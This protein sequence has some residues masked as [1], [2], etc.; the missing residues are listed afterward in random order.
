MGC[1]IHIYREKFSNEA[2][3]GRLSKFEKRELT[4][5]MID[6]KIFEHRWIS[7]DDWHIETY[8]RKDDV[9]YEE[10]WYTQRIEY[11]DRNYE[12]FNCL[13]GGVRG[14]S[15]S[16]SVISEPK[17]V[18]L[19]SSKAYLKEVDYADG[20]GHSHSFLTLSELRKGLAKIKVLQNYTI[21]QY[22]SM[23]HDLEELNKTNDG[24][25]DHVRICFFFDS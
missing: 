19:N 6:D 25:P 7:A 15:T 10:Y 17:G 18:D 13:A 8:G 12:F 16:S 20:D 1:D 2:D 23:L 21:E 3:Y 24:N 14:D 9:D 22:K 11:G 4:L 5:E